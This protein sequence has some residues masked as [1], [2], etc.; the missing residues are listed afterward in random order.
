MNDSF[1]SFER[2]QF[3]KKIISD[4]PSSSG[5]YL[6]KDKE[7]KVLYVGKAKSLKN[8]VKSYFSSNLPIKVKRLM[9]R[10]FDIEFFL[11]NSEYEA[12]LLE[13]NLIKKYS[14][15]YN[16]SL[17]DG[18]TY[19]V[20]RITNEGFP[21]VFRTREIIRDGSLYYGPYVNLYQ[22]DTILKAIDQ[23]YPLRKCKEIPLRKRKEPCLFYH[24]GRCSAPCIGNISSEDYQENLKEVKELLKGNLKDFKKVLSQKMWEASHLLEFEKASFLS[25]VLDSLERV[26][27][28]QNVE[29][30]TGS[31]SDY[32]ALLKEEE[33]SCLAVIQVREGKLL[34]KEIFFFENLMFE[35]ENLTQFI[36][37][38]YE[39]TQSLPQEIYLSF[40]LDEEEKA[41]LE[42]GFKERNSL[43]IKILNPKAGHHLKLL[44]IAKENAHLSYLSRYKE[45][46]ALFELQTSLSLPSL[47]LRIEGIDIA[48]ID[49]KYPVG[50]V[51]SFFEGVPD[52]KSYRL[53]NLRSLEG[54]IDDYKAIKEVI[55]RHYPKSDKLPDLLLIDGGKGQLS[56]ASSV[57]KELG[58]SF[59]VASLAKR[60]E[61]VFLVGKREPHLFPKGNRAL[62]ILQAV[63]DESHR[64]STNQ[65]RKLMGKRFSSLP[66]QEIEGMGEVRAKQVLI[67]FPSWKDLEK[68][69]QEELQS[70]AS[71]SK[72]LSEKLYLWVQ[73]K[74]EFKE[75]LEFNF[76][77]FITNDKE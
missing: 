72:T 45:K 7:G 35:E 26:E 12:L 47:P 15:F 74:K 25:S 23:I 31:S 18:K 39:K 1:V 5:C 59:P 42:K 41:L 34:G 37:Q 30:L 4:F 46:N 36:W 58:F 75:I 9:L 11:T 48:H 16:I 64:F 61:E 28:S 53:Y 20:I 62:A 67:A 52:K 71:L 63:R 43:S 70:K 32:L 54:N 76:D 6:M 49:G 65:N 21:R 40:S 17:K 27:F 8:R 55:A 68:A 66:W 13:N 51:V 24:L 33:V 2:N 14:P 44:N 3:L 56:S 38:F 19:P 60:E 50:V 57:L 73:E 77:S 29:K 69:S 22:M 10:V